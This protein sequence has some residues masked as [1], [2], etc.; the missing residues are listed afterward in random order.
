MQCDNEANVYKLLGEFCVQFEQVCRSMEVCIRTILANQGLTNERVHEILLADYTAEPLRKLLQSLVGEVLAKDSQ[1][2][3][4][5]SKVFGKLQELTSERN[6]IVHSKWFILDVTN[7]VGTK[8]FLVLGEK[9]H[10]NREGA[11]TKRLKLDRARLEKNI[12]KCKE[13]SILLKLL[14]R[15]ILG[16]RKLNE[17][18]KLNKD[19]LTWSKDALRPLKLNV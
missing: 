8:N 2:V 19:G 3:K 9:L 1:D 15:C 7:D 13:A 11:A 12:A 17:C 14:M 4:I 18:Y 6:D 10:A 5:C 16:L